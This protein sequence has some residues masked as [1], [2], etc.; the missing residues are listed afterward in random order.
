MLAF[1]VASRDKLVSYYHTTVRVIM[2][3]LHLQLVARQLDSPLG[4]TIMGFAS[5]MVALLAVTQSLVINVGLLFLILSFP[6]VLVCLFNSKVGFLITVLFSTFIFYINRIL[7]MELPLGSMV[8]AM[9]AITFIGI[10]TKRSNFKSDAINLFKNPITLMVVVWIVYLFFQALNPNSVSIDAWLFS[11]RATF[12]LI[13]S[14]F[15]ILRIF[16]NRKFVFFFTKFWLFIAVLA[17]LYGM[18][19]EVF[20]LPGYDLKWVTSNE[21][22]IGLNYIAGRW[23]KWSFMSDSAAFGMFMAFGSTFCII[24]FL[25]PFSWKKKIILLASGLLMLVSMTF[26]GTRTAF[27]M[28]PVGFLIYGIMTLNKRVTI[29]FGIIF[30]IGFIILLQGPFYGGIINRVRTAFDPMNDPSMQVR[31]INRNRIQPYIYEHPMGGGVNTT[32]TFGLIYSPGH[33]LAGFPPDSFYLQTA[34]ETGWIGL[35]I[36]LT[37]FFMV[38]YVGVRNYFKVKDPKI[39]ALYLA[40][41]SVFFAITIASFSKKAV[42]QYPIGFIFYAIYVLMY[43][44]Q[45]FDEA[46]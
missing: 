36:Q 43:R 21:G 10:Y 14:Y 18:Y 1:I 29:L 25:G 3:W 42:I 19:Q 24:L 17:A 27:A 6:I 7:G 23:R 35:L 2:D 12:S 37:T 11:L 4:Y 31:D 5:I 20:G 16:D 13:F 9:L 22:R 30:T 44:L 26:S 28:V 33:P 41:I 32:G 34:L 39:K 15:I 45:E 40:Y 38:L 8:D 46:S